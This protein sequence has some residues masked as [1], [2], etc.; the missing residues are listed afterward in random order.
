MGE[1]VTVMDGPF[2]T[3]PAT[4]ADIDNTNQKLRVLVSIFGRET[5]LELG[6]EQVAKI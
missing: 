5:P 1:S 6:F 4:I 3:M 2:E